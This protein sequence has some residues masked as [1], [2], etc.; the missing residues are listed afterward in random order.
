MGWES[1]FNN[2]KRNAV[3][4]GTGIL[5]S[6]LSQ[7]LDRLTHRIPSEYL[8]VLGAAL[9]ASNV[10]PLQNLMFA[11]EISDIALPNHAVQAINLPTFQVDYRSQRQRGLQAYYPKALNFSSDLTVRFNEDREGSILMYYYY[12]IADMFVMHSATTTGGAENIP[13]HSWRYSADKKVKIT[14][15]ILSGP[16]STPVLSIEYLRC[17]PAGF[18]G[19]DFDAAGGQ[20][21][22]PSI[23][24]KVE[25]MKITDPRQNGTSGSILDQFGQ[26]AQSTVL[27]K[28][29]SYVGY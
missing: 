6:Q 12:K 13:W 21:V 11:V 9:Q 4:Y 3:G 14:V 7:Q 10:D 25:E 1:L 15:R 17:S 20:F 27:G 19:V 26:R 23:S 29:K 18:S 28:L 8:G 2:V 22:Q 16:D 5:Q 24:F